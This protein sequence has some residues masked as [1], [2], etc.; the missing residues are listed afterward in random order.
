MISMSNHRETNMESLLIEKSTLWTMN[1]TPGKRVYGEK[2]RRFSSKEFRKWDPYRSKIAAGMLRTQHDPRNLLPNN[3]SQVLYL[4]AGHG[5]TIS[6]I[7]DIVCGESNKFGGRI[8]GI[9]IS[10]RCIRD[11]L[12][13]AKVRP[14]FIPVL[15]DA[16][17]ST[18]EHA[19]H[20]QVDWLFQDVSQTGQLDIFLDVT[21][22]HL[23]LSGRALFSF[24]MASERWSDEAKTT[25]IETMEKRI[26]SSGF[27]CN[28]ILDLQGYEDE[29]F[30]FVIS[31]NM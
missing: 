11:L 14:G 18:W 13:L 7:H 16:R 27:D 25:Q 23:K 30:L 15:A 17:K 24:K 19:V 10:P 4:G 12:G 2:T 31:K 1:A 5:T 3:G 8:V 9:D 26:A 20:G 28:E 21:S 29:H 6:H 22:K